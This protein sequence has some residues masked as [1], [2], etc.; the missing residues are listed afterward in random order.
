MI[1][2]IQDLEKQVATKHMKKLSLIA[3]G[4]DEQLAAIALES[5]N[6]DIN[7]AVEYCQTN[8]NGSVSPY[9]SP[10]DNLQHL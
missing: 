9:D 5:T 6:Y 7:A 4:F 2:I 1:N 3:F 8:A 10:Q